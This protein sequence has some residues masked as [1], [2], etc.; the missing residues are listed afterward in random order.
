MGVDP[1]SMAMMGSTLLSAGGSVMEGV[2]ANKMGKY[3]QKVAEMNA[4]IAEKNAREAIATSQVEAQESDMSALAFMGA[5]EAMQGASG[6]SLSGG[7]QVAA[8]EASK[9]LA[10]QDAL[11]IREAGNRDAF[12][13]RTQGVNFIAEGKMAKAQGK[14]A[15]TSGFIN[16]GSSLLTGASRVMKHKQSLVT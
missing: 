13:F 12:N 1:I 16:A 15:L 6:L 3:Q 4:E 7:S 2:A 8:R 11:R 10:R 5:Q 9:R 14:N